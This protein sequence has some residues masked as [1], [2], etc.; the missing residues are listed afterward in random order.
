MDFLS[1]DILMAIGSI[2]LLDI[3]LGG[4]NAVV[5]AMASRDLPLSI[6]KKAIYVGTAGALIIRL[7]MTFLAVKLLTVPFLQAIG[8]L[9]LIPIAYK[10][11]KPTEEEKELSS[12]ENFWTAI[13]TIIVRKSSRG[14]M[15]KK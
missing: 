10:L 7:L 9:A 12:C 5:I 14:K 11:L 1:M 3:V 6:R 15:L 4:D 2:I 13:K 8:G